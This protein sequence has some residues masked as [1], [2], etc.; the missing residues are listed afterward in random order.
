MIIT[1]AKPA[2]TKRQKQVFADAQQCAHVW[3]QQSQSYGCNPS[4][5]VYFEST[6]IYSYGSHFAMARFAGRGVV[7]V[8]ANGY[9][10]ST[11]RHQRYVADA[12]RGLPVTKIY[13]DDP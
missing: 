3:A 4:R 7:L 12:L 13:V 1:T 2:R 9:S 6:A 8:N 11:S 5:N 10:V